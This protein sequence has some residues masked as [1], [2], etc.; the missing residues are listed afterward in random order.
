MSE[1]RPWLKSYPAGIRAEIDS[2]DF[3]SIIELVD[4]TCNQYST[5]PAFTNMGHSFSFRELQEQSIR[6]AA[7]LQKD[8][9]LKKG[10]RIAI[11]MPNLLQ[12]PI[13]LFGALRAGLIV[14]M[15]SGWA[16]RMRVG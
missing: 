3:R 8:L 9:G 10:D 16:G 7:F 13:A 12:Y 6:F 14:V 1:S 4:Q 11:Q 2:G 15:P 5:L